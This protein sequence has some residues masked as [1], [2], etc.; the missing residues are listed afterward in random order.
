MLVLIN[1]HSNKQE[2]RNSNGN[3]TDEHS[4][5]SLVYWTN[6]LHSLENTIHLVT[7]SYRS[8]SDIIHTYGTIY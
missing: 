8:I 2:S 4:S 3:N 7:L 5:K 6:D 1:A